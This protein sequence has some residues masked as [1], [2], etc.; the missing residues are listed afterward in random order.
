MAKDKPKTKDATDHG[1]GA[2]YADMLPEDYEP[3]NKTSSGG[4]V[5]VGT[6]LGALGKKK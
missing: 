6:F 5:T 1:Y 3:K 4:A 2:A